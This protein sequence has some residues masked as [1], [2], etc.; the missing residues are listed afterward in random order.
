VREAAAR[1]LGRLH[2]TKA[3]PTLIELIG[4]DS[5]GSVRRC[6]RHALV[7]LGAVEQLKNN[8]MRLW[9]LRIIDVSRARTVAAHHSQG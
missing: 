4:Y 3:I 1:S 7:Q 2:A 6:A 8:P 9:P 5:D